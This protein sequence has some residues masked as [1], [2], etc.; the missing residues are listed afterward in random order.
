MFFSIITKTL[1]QEILTKN[2]VTFKIWEGFKD[3]RIQFYGGSLKDP[4]FR[5]VHEKP[6]YREESP[7]K[8]A[9]AVWRLKGGSWQKR[10]GWCF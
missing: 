1:N 3:E 7:K 4:I 2:L 6:I 5:R 8:E 9:W 10:E